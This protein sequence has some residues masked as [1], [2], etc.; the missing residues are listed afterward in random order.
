MEATVLVKVAV[1][2]IVAVRVKL[3]ATL[4]TNPFTELIVA[5]RVRLLETALSQATCRAM[6]ADKVRLEATVSK[7]FWIAPTVVA[8]VALTPHGAESRSHTS[9]SP[10]FA[11]HFGDA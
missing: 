5:D 7:Y 2:A 8:I 10:V 9:Q 3:E 1:L 4:L 6:V 11:L